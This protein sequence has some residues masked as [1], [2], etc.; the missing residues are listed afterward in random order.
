[1]NNADKPT[2]RV[3][4]HKAGKPHDREIFY[5]LAENESDARERCRVYIKREFNVR[6]P[7]WLEIRELD[8]TR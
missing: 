3:A 6:K 5:C 1:M 8:T 4:W 7:T 2:W